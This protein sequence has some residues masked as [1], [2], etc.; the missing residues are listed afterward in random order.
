VNVW[1]QPEMGCDGSHPA[2]CSRRAVLY[3]A[4]P[5]RWD[6]PMAQSAGDS[7][8]PHSRLGRWRSA[9]SSVRT[10]ERTGKPV[11]TACTGCAE[12][13]AT[14][15][16]SQERSDVVVAL[17]A[18][19]NCQACG[20]TRR[21]VSRCSLK[22]SLSRIISIMDNILRYYFTTGLETA[23]LQWQSH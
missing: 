21:P 13:Y 5:A 18:A 2:D 15:G 9:Y 11:R 14:N 3:F 10:L 6:R 7:V 16:G 1:R 23:F 4:S 12:V 17:R 8:I 20:K 19:A 22:L